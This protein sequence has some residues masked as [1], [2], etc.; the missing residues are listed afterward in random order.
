[1]KIDIDKIID[2]NIKVDDCYQ[3]IID[4]DIQVGKV[5]LRGTCLERPLHDLNIEQFTEFFL[6]LLFKYLRTDRNPH[7][8]F[9]TIQFCNKFSGLRSLEELSL[10]LINLKPP[11]HSEN[12]SDILEKKNSKLKLTDSQFESCKKNLKKFHDK[13]ESLEQK[14]GDK[15]ILIN[16]LEQLFVNVN[17][18]IFEKILIDLDFENLSKSKTNTKGGG[19]NKELRKTRTGEGIEILGAVGILLCSMCRALIMAGLVAAGSG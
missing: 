10:S 18:E 16:E 19:E 9:T 17:K 13:I 4:K 3:I 5:T 11:G 14:E 12:D 7:E 15:Q 6:K 1:M 2:D 8:K